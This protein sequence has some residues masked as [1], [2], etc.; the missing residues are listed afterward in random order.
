MPLSLYQDRE[1]KWRYVDSSAAY[2]FFEQVVHE[3]RFPQSTCEVLKNYGLPLHHIVFV[4]L[5]LSSLFTNTMGITNDKKGSYRPITSSDT[6]T[7]DESVTNSEDL[8]IKHP[9]RT[10]RSNWLI[11]LALGTLNVVTIIILVALLSQHYT[12]AQCTKRLSLYC[13]CIYR[14]EISC[15]I[16]GQS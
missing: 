9:I 8:L 11:I 7:D 3:A 10:R 13:K 5:L 1:C 12:D 2:L 4:I 14:I 15:H 6:H 16:H